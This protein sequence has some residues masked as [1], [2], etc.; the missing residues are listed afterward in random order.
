MDGH[1]MRCGTIGSCPPAA[2]EVGLILAFIMNKVPVYTVVQKNAP[3]L[4]DYNYDPVQ[5]ILI[6]FSKL[7]TIIKVVW[8]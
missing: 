7:L 2:C 4:A 6:I 5:S 3:T 1:I 8:L